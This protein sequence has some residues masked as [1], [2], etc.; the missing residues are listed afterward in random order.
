LLSV[1]AGTHGISGDSELDLESARIEEMIAALASWCPN[2]S[3]TSCLR[4]R[5]S[6]MRPLINEG[7]IMAVDYSQTNYATLDGKIVIAWHKNTG[8][9]VS[10]FRCY[11]GIA[12][13]EAENR[14]YHPVTIG[15]D[16]DWRIVG[17]ILWW[18]RMAP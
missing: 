14:E 7:D 6:S 8:L 16:R 15:S 12:V 2:P 10:R 13:L 3:S 17:R 5:G 9:S 11:R 1:C 18:T 4:V